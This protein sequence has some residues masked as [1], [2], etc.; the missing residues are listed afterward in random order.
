MQTARPYNSHMQLIAI[1]ELKQLHVYKKLLNLLHL[2]GILFV[3]LI[4]SSLTSID[5]LIAKS[6]N[7][8]C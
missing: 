4:Q 1:I 2:F 7:N 6:I 8:V 3:T 5:Y